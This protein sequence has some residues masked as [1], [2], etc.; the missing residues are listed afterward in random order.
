MTMRTGDA[1]ALQCEL[2]DPPASGLAEREAAE[3]AFLAAVGPAQRRAAGITFT[4]LWLV[5]LML[6]RAAARGDFDTIVDPGAGSGRFAFAAARR[7]PK[8][9]VVAVEREPR[10]ADLLRRRA[11][12]EG[13]RDRIT[14]IE[15]D[16][17]RIAIEP[18]GRSLYIGNPPYVR[19]H[20]IEAPWKDW[21]A[22]GMTE[23]GIAASRLAGLHAHF[24]LRI[25]QLLRPGDAW[26]LVTAAEWMDNGYGAAVRALLGGVGG[27]GLRALWLAAPD[28]P[29]FPDALVSAVVVL[30]EASPPDE[31]ELGRLQGRCLTATRSLRAELVASNARWSPLCQPAAIPAADGIELGALFRIVRGQ[32]TGMNSA[33]VIPAAASAEWRALSVPAVTRAREIIDGTVASLQ[34]TRLLKRV[35]DLPAEPDALP[36]E[37]RAAA[38]E[39]IERARRLGA[40][41]GYIA[42]QRRAWY[43]VGMRP[44]PLA[45]V[46]YMGRRPP[47][48]CTNPGRVSFLNIAHGLYPRSELRD[49][50]L[51]RVLAHLN[52]AVDL[53]AG[54]VYGGGLAKFEPSDVARLR[55]PATVWSEPA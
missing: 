34:A 55:L 5:D 41:R 1:T 4:P 46:S 30:G 21:Y 33:W 38:M 22:Q 43:A 39:L 51:D 13:L 36:P 28:E 32:V 54:R 24:M 37:A 7:F 17:R 45:F 35:I 2:F 48:F 6:E 11:W 50:D 14:V 19:H 20:E 44:P 10:L 52:S 42:R 53:F 9:R 8:A 18:A 29:V 31:V 12:R 16:F 25:S 49:G 27:M 40:D 15:G 23:Q 47:V 26:C 3:E